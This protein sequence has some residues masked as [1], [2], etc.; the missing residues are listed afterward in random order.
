MQHPWP[1]YPIHH[2]FFEGS[3]FWLHNL[4]SSSCEVEI[5][6]ITMP[7]KVSLI[8]AANRIIQASTYIKT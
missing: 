1:V 4:L 2:M 7:D 5:E 8:S 6:A 3:H